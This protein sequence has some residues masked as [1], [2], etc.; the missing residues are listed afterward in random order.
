MVNIARWNP[1]KTV[2]SFDPVATFEDMFRGLRSHPLWNEME[3]TPLMRLDV[4]EDEKSFLVRAEMPGISKN[5]IEIS[6]EGNQVAISAEV[7]RETGKKDADRMHLHTERY[8]GKIYRAFTLPNDLDST[9]ADA[10]YENGVLTLTLPK[11]PNGTS[12]KLTVN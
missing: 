7:K 4:T 3:P 11:K 8:Y 10:R 5:D 1:V 9:Q 12:R 2:S 6:V